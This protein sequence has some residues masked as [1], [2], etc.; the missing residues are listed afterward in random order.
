MNSKR[1]L[2]LVIVAIV[3]T[4]TALSGCLSPDPSSPWIMHEGYHWDAQ[5]QT[6]IHISG[7]RSHTIAQYDY[8]DLLFQ[9]LKAQIIGIDDIAKLQFLPNQDWLVIKLGSRRF[10]LGDPISQGGL[11][12]VSPDGDF[13][14]IFHPD[15]Q[16]HLI[17]ETH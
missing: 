5:T 16:G 7:D 12:E 1:K 14:D 9:M 8:K 2:I 4:I 6:M 10:W 3:L 13:I 15:D 11:T 17:P